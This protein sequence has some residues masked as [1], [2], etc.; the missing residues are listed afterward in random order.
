[1]TCSEKVSGLEI[2][3]VMKRMKNNEEEVEFVTVWRI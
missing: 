1:M 3:L 2:E